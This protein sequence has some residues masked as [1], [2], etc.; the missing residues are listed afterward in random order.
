MS[1]NLKEKYPGLRKGSWLCQFR[2]GCNPWMARYIYGLMFLITN[3]LAWAIRDYGGS[4]VKEI[5][6]KSFLF[7]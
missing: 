4:A 5:E 1:N 7:P 3:L 6:S 2:Y